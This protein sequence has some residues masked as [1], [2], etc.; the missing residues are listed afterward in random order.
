MSER[1]GPRESAGE[2]SGEASGGTGES[3]QDRR[4][5][6][7]GEETPPPAPASTLVRGWER[8]ADLWRGRR[9]RIGD[10][11]ARG[12]WGLRSVSPV[13]VGAVLVLALLA[14]LYFSLDGLMD[15]YLRHPAAEP[16]AAPQE[17]S[18]TLAEDMREVLLFYPRRDG[19][20]LG[21]EHGRIFDLES[22]SARGKIVLE[23]LSEGPKSAD[24]APALPKGSQVRELWITP[25]GTAYVD[26]SAELG[27][28]HPG[29]TTA[30]TATV[31]SIV[32]SLAYN[33]PEVRRVQILMEGREVDTLSGHLALW[34]PLAADLSLVESGGPAAPATARA[35]AP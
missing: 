1:E 2:G 14:L 24:L 33:I 28:N 18:L 9:L 29:G 20:G 7:E 35:A 34:L 3:A 25:S 8:H 17:P 10:W 12:G 11:W 5:G 16:P 22:P 4:A 27:R 26:F 30:E 32:N 6:T 21:V 31:Y 19:T 23:R 15:R 13:L